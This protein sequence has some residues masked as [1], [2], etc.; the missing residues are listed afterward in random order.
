[1]SIRLRAAIGGAGELV[2]PDDTA[3]AVNGKT[4]PDDRLEQARRELRQSIATEVS[5]ELSR[6]SSHI[7]ETIVLDLD[8][9]YF[10]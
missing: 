10:E 5:D 7:F 2:V 8:S 1:M 3:A 6:V 4:S 9:D